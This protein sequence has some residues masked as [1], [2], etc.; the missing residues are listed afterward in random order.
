[1]VIEPQPKPLGIS[2]SEILETYHIPGESKY[3]GGRA[4]DIMQYEYYN[5]K[6]FRVMI[7]FKETEIGKC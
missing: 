2:D 7:F 3:I 4:T 6:L 1:M 5:D